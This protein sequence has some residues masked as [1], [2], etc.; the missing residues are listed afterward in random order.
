M[1]YKELPY[2]ERV[3]YPYQRKCLQ[4][5]KQ[6]RVLS[7]GFDLW[8]RAE[9]FR[10][11]LKKV[12][13]N[14]PKHWYLQFMKMGGDAREL[15]LL[16]PR[17]MHALNSSRRL[18]RMQ[19]SGIR[20]CNVMPERHTFKYVSDVIFDSFDGA[21][22]ISSGLIP[23]VKNSKL[24]V[25]FKPS[26]K[27]SR[28]YRDSLMVLHDD[29]FS[30]LL[31]RSHLSPAVFEITDC[32][33]DKPTSL[34]VLRWEVSSPRLDFPQLIR[35]IYL[36]LGDVISHFEVVGSGAHVRISKTS[37]FDEDSYMV[38]ECDRVLHLN[39]RFRRFSTFGIYHNN[40]QYQIY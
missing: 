19:I 2:I 3:G 38:R 12:E 1:S 25:E 4:P 10:R 24:F 18:R 8:D 28:S 36:A 34:D 9:M 30:T 27:R 35:I 14:H 40:P 20:A 39:F 6:P 22:V 37:T 23:H 16:V 33:P 15:T 26:P 11:N 17:V 5:L 13:A 29:Y 31:R 21:C 7:T 32:I